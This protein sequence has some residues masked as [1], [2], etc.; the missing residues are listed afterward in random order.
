MSVIILHYSYVLG[1]NSF[2]TAT[3]VQYFESQESV[4]RPS[5]AL[6]V[7]LQFRRF[8]INQHL[9]RLRERASNAFISLAFSPRGN[10]ACIWGKGEKT[11][12]YF[13][14]LSNFACNLKPLLMCCHIILYSPVL[15][16][17]SYFPDR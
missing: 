5:F 17:F 1:H 11:L 15:Q 6:T 4:V 2:N 8:R 13:F 3:F 7:T 14:P 9:I 16:T 10:C 12:K